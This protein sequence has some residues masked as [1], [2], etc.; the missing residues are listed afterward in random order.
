MTTERIIICFHPD[1]TFRGASATDYGGQPVEISAS[2][3]PSLGIDIAALAR[4][5]E[6]EAEIAALQTAPQEQAPPDAI[7]AWQAKAVLLLMGLLAASE[8][9]IESLEEPQRTI[10]K[11]AWDNNADF[12]RQ[13]PTILSIAAA[14][15]LSEEQVNTMFEQAASLSV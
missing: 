11:S 6:L 1:G 5:A 2:E 8:S 10:I 9:V 14:L 7:K 12:P 3:I 15:S 4:I 13:S